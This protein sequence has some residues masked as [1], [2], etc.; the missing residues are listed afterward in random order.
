MALPY[1]GPPL[2]LDTGFVF[3]GKIPVYINQ[4][5]FTLQVIIVQN[6]LGE[7]SCVV[8]IYPYGQINVLYIYIRSPINGA[9]V[10][11]WDPSLFPLGMRSG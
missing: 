7:I 4:V 9:L 8:S 2:K 10:P 3:G 6:E 11:A 1:Y 5:I